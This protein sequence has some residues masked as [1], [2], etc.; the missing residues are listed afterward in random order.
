MAEFL[1]KTGLQS[2]VQDIKLYIGSKLPAYY[3]EENNKSK[4]SVNTQINGNVSATTYIT[5]GFGSE[6][7]AT[8]EEGQI[9]FLIN[10]D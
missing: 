7:P 2:L 5:Q 3:T 4:I 1:S 8:G 9:F 6:L 10:E